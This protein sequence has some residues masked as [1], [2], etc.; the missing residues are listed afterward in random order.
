MVWTTNRSIV[1]GA[2]P[3][4]GSRSVGSP[5]RSRSA[6]R[7]RASATTAASTRAAGN[8]YRTPLPKTPNRTTAPSPSPP[9]G[10][11]RR[12]YQDELLQRSALG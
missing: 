6:T 4:T 3:G 5:M 1:P 11:W 2:T 7:V 10:R 8:R 9:A 12:L